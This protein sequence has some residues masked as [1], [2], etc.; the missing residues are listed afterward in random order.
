MTVIEGFVD[1][2]ANFATLALVEVEHLFEEMGVDHTAMVLAGPA[3][4]PRYGCCGA[5]AHL[6]SKID[7]SRIGAPA[8]RA[9]VTAGEYAYTRL[10]GVHVVPLACLGP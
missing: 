3:T 9:V 6:V 4:R 2:V 10:D 7:T 8:A 5:P 1:R